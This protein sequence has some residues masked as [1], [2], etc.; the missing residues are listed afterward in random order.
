M[1][2]ERHTHGIVILDIAR[3]LVIIVVVES[4][5]AITGHTTIL[6]KV[7]IVPVLAFSA[8]IL[9]TGRGAAAADGP[10]GSRCL[11]GFRVAKRRLQKNGIVMRSIGGQDYIPVLGL[12]RLIA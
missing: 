10:T 6:I 5:A 7:E 12:N 11:P 9:F 3:L 1:P 2:E 8:Q 4:F